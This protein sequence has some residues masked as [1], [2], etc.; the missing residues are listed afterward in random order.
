MEVVTD[1][2]FV[3]WLVKFQIRGSKKDTKIMHSSLLFKDIM[4]K[5]CSLSLPKFQ[6]Q[7]F[8][9]KTYYY[10]ADDIYFKFLIFSL[11]HSDTRLRKENMFGAHHFSAKKA[12]E[13]AFSVLLKHFKILY[14]PSRLRGV[15]QMDVI[16]GAC[17]IL[18][19]MIDQDRKYEGTICFR[20]KTE[21][22]TEILLHLKRVMHVE[23]RYEWGRRWREQYINVE[24]V[25][26]GKYVTDAMIDHVWSRAGTNNRSNTGND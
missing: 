24:D 13:G 1:N 26:Q 10:L 22:D 20:E 21:N 6:L 12:F 25:G 17:C 16:V 2:N 15:E 23:C 4:N 3:I 8:T 5:I 9:V 11:P 7:E 19:N 18:H 14:Y